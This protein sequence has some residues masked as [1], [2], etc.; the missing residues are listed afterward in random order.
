[1]LKGVGVQRSKRGAPRRSRCVVG[2]HEWRAARSCSSSLEASHAGARRRGAPAAS[3]SGAS[4]FSRVAAA[5]PRPR[6]LPN[7]LGR[8]RLREKSVEKSVTVVFFSWHCARRGDAMPRESMPLP[9]CCPALCRGRTGAGGGGAR[10]HRSRRGSESSRG[11]S[12][13][14][15]RA[16]RRAPISRRRGLRRPLRRCAPQAVM[17][18]TRRGRQRRPDGAP[19]FRRCSRAACRPAPR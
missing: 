7:G 10:P 8:R 1:M 15:C 18:S 12:S 19:M 14:R 6:R 3:R 9:R 5:A 4:V 17:R 13:G 11:A 16:G 2:S